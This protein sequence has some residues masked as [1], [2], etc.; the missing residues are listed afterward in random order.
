[1]LAALQGSCVNF[2]WTPLPVACVACLR[3][4]MFLFD[5]FWYIVRFIFRALALATI[6]TLSTSSPNYLSAFFNTSLVWKHSYYFILAAKLSVQAS[7]II[8]WAYQNCMLF[9]ALNL[10]SRLI[11]DHVIWCITFA[12]P[13][14]YVF[15][16]VPISWL[17][18]FGIF[19]MALVFP[20]LN[21]HQIIFLYIFSYISTLKALNYSGYF[22]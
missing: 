17:L 18:E 13:H 11:G 16:G 12:R 10:S 6:I 5:P 1:M 4:C 19:C 21:I 15:G 7:C 20:L 22:S 8:I 2:K 9:T 3:M 14:H